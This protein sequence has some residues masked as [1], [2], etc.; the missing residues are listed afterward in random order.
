MKLIKLS[1]LKY[2]ELL[3]FTVLNY[4]DKLISFSLPLVILYIYKDISLYNDFE[5]IYSAANIIVVIADLGIRG[6]FLYDFSKFNNN[7]GEYASRVY[8]HV[9]TLILFYSVFF[10]T[11]IYLG[12]YF[13]S[14]NTELLYFILIRTLLLFYINF[15]IM[16]TRIVNN[17][18]YG[19]YLSV[20]VNVIVVSFFLFNKYIYQITATATVLNTVFF[21]QL[22]C[23]VG[24][25]FKS[26]LNISK[27]N[28][29]QSIVYFRKALLYSWPIIVNV[30]LITVVNNFGKLYIHK[31]LPAVDMYMFSYI[32]RVGMIIQMAHVSVVAFFSKSIFL[33][34]KK[35]FNKKIYFLYNVFLTLAVILS[36]LIIYVSQFFNFLPTIEIDFMVVI[37]Y[38]YILIWCQQSYFEIYINKFNK[39]KYLMIFTICS[40]CIYMLIVGVNYSSLSMTTISLAMLITA[41]INFLCVF[42]YVRRLFLNS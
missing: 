12:D 39:N 1:L 7:L 3:F 36:G 17:P 29:N 14:I 41:V 32:L 9:T 22:I 18:N 35:S 21:I 13:F 20:F 40:L 15:F 5:Y 16:Y 2:N 25:I 24:I 38:L 8:R 6:F 37:L 11:I 33:D 31:N 26:K 28:I 10:T 19:L 23:I 27:E 4:F 42:I 30:L 34:E